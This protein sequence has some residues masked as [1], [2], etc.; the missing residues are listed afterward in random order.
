[1]TYI[2]DAENW[3]H[4]PFF[5]KNPDRIG[6]NLVAERQQ[7]DRSR[8]RETIHQAAGIG[9]P[10]LLVANGTKEEFGITEDIA[11]CTVPAAPAGFGFVSALMQYI[12]GSLLAGY[13][14]TLLLEPFFRGR[15]G[16]FADPRRPIFYSSVE[17]VS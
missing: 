10:V 15:A 3:C 6:T 1:M 12:P 5:Q 9:R 13:V 11:V 2:D 14:L 16:A 8:I 7:N 4:L 17:V